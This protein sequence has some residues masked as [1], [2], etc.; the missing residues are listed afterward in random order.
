MLLGKNINWLNQNSSLTSY[1]FDSD[2]F[3]DKVNLFEFARPAYELFNG[4]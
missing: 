3:N 4:T 1:A 2:R